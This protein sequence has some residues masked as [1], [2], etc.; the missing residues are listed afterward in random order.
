VFKFRFGLLALGLFVAE[1]ASG[2]QAVL[3]DTPYVDPKGF[4]KIVPPQGWSIKEYS[5]DPRG[6]VDFDLAPGPL[7]AQLKVI[8]QI[9]PYSGFEALLRDVELQLARMRERHGASTNVDK[10]T[11]DGEPAVRA[12]IELPGKLKQLN[13][14]ML[15]GKS[16]YTMAYGARPDLFDKYRPLVDKSIESFEPVAK[17]WSKEEAARHVAAGAI[18]RANLYIQLGRKDWA[19]KAIEEGLAYSPGNKDLIALKKQIQAR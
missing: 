2:Q 10:V 6:K 5:A 16:H 12:T 11:V 19:L 13:L 3:S 17:E 4:F 14:Q 9:S 7:T 8:G 15:R 1:L 18:R